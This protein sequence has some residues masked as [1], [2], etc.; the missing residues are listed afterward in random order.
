MSHTIARRVAPA[1]AALALAAGTAAA[2]DVSGTWDFQVDLDAGSGEATFVLVQQGDSLSG[3]Y[4]GVLGEQQVRGTVEGNVVRFGFSEGQVGT[5]SYEG[6][7]EG[8]TMQGRCSYGA[9]GDGSF[10]GTKRSGE[11]SF[12]RGADEDDVATPRG[13]GV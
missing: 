2:Q 9:L 11:A 3:T 1:L 7:I 12:P 6:T 4:N 13:P 10:R 5:V 8:N